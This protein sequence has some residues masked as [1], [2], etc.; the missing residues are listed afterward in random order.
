[1]SKASV[2]LGLVLFQDFE[3]PGQINFGGR[4]ALAIHRL[5]G[6]GRVIDAMGRDDAE[7][8]FSGIFSGPDATRRARMLDG[9]RAAGQTQPLSW[10]VFSYAVVIRNF[11]AD[12]RAG[13]WIPFF[14]ACS[15]LRDEA[16]SVVEVPLPLAE[17]ILND[18]GVAAAIGVDL[19]QA[20][21]ALAEPDATTRGTPA[22]ARASLMLSQAEA[23]IA[24][25][26][27]VADHA[28]PTAE[29]TDTGTLLAAEAALGR[30]A[31]LAVARAHVGRARINLADAAG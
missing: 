22:H 2:I 6:G 24:A 11:Q 10:D 16:A 27:L 31:D 17:L 3:I 8:T 1:M 26:I 29:I 18:I 28:L 20:I 13:N 19:G 14:L 5:P 4:Q 15:V 7:I 12:Y 21:R 30:L 9:M 23:D 25:S